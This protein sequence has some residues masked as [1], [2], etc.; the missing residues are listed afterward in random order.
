MGFGISQFGFELA[1]PYRNKSFRVFRLQV[2]VWSRWVSSL[3]S[4]F[5]ALGDNG[6]KIGISAFTGLAWSKVF[7]C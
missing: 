4:G 5:Q 2:Q 6:L 1:A 3:G 7:G